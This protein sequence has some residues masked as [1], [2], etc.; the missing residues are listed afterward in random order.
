MAGTA[1]ISRSLLASLP[2]PAPGDP[3][4]L[5]PGCHRSVKSSQAG[6]P[7]A[8][9]A[10]GARRPLCAN[11]CPPELAHLPTHVH[12]REHPEQRQPVPTHPHLHSNG[13]CTFITSG[14][15]SLRQIHPETGRTVCSWRSI[16]QGLGCLYF[17]PSLAAGRLGSPVQVT[18]PL[19]SER[20]TFPSFS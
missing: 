20:V 16:M 14:G 18:F 7:A 3:P 6:S 13:P 12:T 1:S 17:P 19:C 9:K 10:T 2:V 15:M 8:V 4:H 5:L 11:K